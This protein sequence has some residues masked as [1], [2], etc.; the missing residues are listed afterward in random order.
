MVRGAA[1]SA[2]LGVPEMRPPGDKVSATA[3][4]AVPEATENEN[5]PPAPPLAVSVCEYGV[6]IVPAGK[7]VG[8]AEMSGYTV[9]V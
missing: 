1:V 8:V 6:P 5:G 4:S 2:A 7:V 3:E 9:S